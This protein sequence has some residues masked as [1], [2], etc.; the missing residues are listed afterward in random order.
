MEEVPLDKRRRIGMGKM[1]GPTTN[2]A[3]SR[4]VLSAVN[5]ALHPPGNDPACS[6]GGS[7]AGGGMEFSCRDDVERLLNEKMKG[8]NK[9]DYKVSPFSLELV[10]GVDFVVS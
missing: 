2:S 5:T 4:S 7:S 9:T 6:D 10:T 1:V 8:K 3:R